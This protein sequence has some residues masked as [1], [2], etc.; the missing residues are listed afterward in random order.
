MAT[1]FGRDLWCRTT[2]ITTRYATG[3]D[4]LVNALARRITTPRGKLYFHP[5]YGFDVSQLI[6]LEITPTSV[7]GIKAELE[8][9]IE[10]DPRVFDGSVTV[11]IAEVKHATRTDLEIS[12]TGDSELGPFDFVTTIDRVT[13]ELI[14]VR[15]AA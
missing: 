1:D 12:A 8:S 6:G 4:L 14:N 5:N 2:L 7:I 3:M 11:T 9:E 15:R 13:L 10:A